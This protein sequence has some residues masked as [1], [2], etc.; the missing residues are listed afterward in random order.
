MAV[1]L[2]VLL[3]EGAALRQRASQRAQEENTDQLQREAQESQR[4]RE[5]LET[6]REEEMMKAIALDNGAYVTCARITYA[7]M[8]CVS[9]AEDKYAEY[10]T[11]PFRYD[12]H[13]EE[14]RGESEVSRP[15]CQQHISRCRILTISE[16]HCAGRW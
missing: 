7:L 11:V 6:W 8:L 9:A 4:A 14:W 10:R 1:N 15:L 2:N 3:S 5:K 13:R 12:A 16:T